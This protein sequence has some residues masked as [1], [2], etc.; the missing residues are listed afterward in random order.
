MATRYSPRS[1]PLSDTG[2][3]AES[4][5]SRYPAIS[6]REVEELIEIFPKLPILD[7]G[8][9]TADER[10]SANIAEFHKAHGKKL[11]ASNTSLIIL[12]VAFL[13][14][15]VITISVFWLI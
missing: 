12:L 14:V 4:L 15:P 9:M 6:D 11:K 2:L 7:L 5:L 1:R 3:R 13:V 8:L 10:I